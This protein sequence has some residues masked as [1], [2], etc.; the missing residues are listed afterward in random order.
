MTRQADL[1]PPLGWQGGPCKVVERIEDNVRAPSL[2]EDLS[3]KVERGTKLTNPEA[4]KVYTV[5]TE[6]VRGLFKQIKISPHAQYRMDQRGVTVGDLRVFFADF[7]KQFNDWKSQQ[8]WEY[9]R[10]SEAIARGEPIEWVDPRIGHLF[11][12]FATSGRGVADIVTTYWQ[13]EPDPRAETCGTHPEHVRTAR[14]VEDMSGI[15]TLVKSPTPSKSDTDKPEGEDGKYP[16]QGLPSPW[17]RTKP[18]RGP[19]VL[20]VPGESGSDSS[21]T[22]HE[23]KVRTKGTPGGQYN[24]GDTHPTPDITDSQITPHRRP[25]MAAG[26][27]DIFE[28]MDPA[29]VAEAVRLAGMYPPAFPMGQKRHRKQKGQ[30]YRYDHKRYKRQRG[31]IKRRN[32]RRYKV[33][34][35]NGRFQAQRDREDKYPERF[36][37]KPSGG[38][39]TI[40]ERSQKQ[41][42]KAKKKAFRPVPF[43]HYTL[44]QQGWL[45]EVTPEGFVHYDIRGERGE[46]DLN[47]FFDEVVVDDE[48]FDALMAYID[49]VLGASDE[50]DIDDDIDGDT[51]PLF[52]AWLESREKQAYQV[53]QRPARRRQRQRGMDRTQSRMNYRRNR[54]AIRRRSKMRYRRLKNNPAFK[55][56]QKIRR[57]HPE[58]FKM[59][60][61]FQ[62]MAPDIAFVFITDEGFVR[63]YVLRVSGMSKH[64]NYWLDIPG[65]RV[66]QSMPV[67]DFL[68]NAVFLSDDDTDKMF[69]LVDAEIGLDAYD[70]DSEEEA[71]L[72]DDLGD[73]DLEDDL[74]RSVVDHA[75]GR[76]AAGVVA[77]FLY[78]KRPPEMPTDIQYDRANNHDEWKRRDR[79]RLEDISE[80]STNN[81]GEPGSKVL[82]GE[83]AGHIQKQ[84]ALIHDIQAGCSPDLVTKARQ[85][86][87]QMARVDAKNAMWLFNVEGSKEPY[88]VRLQA[89]R[90]GNV[91]ALAKSH[92]RVSCTC[93]F[94]QW[95][96]P[97]HWAKQ[98]EYLYGRPM[99][100]A[101]KPV[102]KDPSGQHRA[103]KHVLATLNFVSSRKW[104]LPELRSKLGS[105]QYLSATLAQSTM[106]WVA[107]PEF[108]QASLRVVARYLASTRRC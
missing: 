12:V 36:K 32:R 50:G 17:S 19:T 105:L 94:W 47:S 60:L 81:D 70:I 52:D 76:W 90:K 26:E 46:T 3:E 8:A 34:K 67:E 5:E 31:T 95:Q 20:N 98:G 7:G 89:I 84:A 13:G 92:V 40:A 41:R 23:D 59:R 96:G 104:D 71:A 56:Q 72:D 108:D 63:G 35:P 29:L 37:T 30:A 68:L 61:G 93:P 51:D 102:V 58:R 75:L 53:Q 100:S 77:D 24:N 64:V 55:R 11:V 14:E 106:G 43:Y 6:S 21:G 25:S 49:Q 86:K 79:K 33:L 38:V 82:P 83:G 44:D 97:E 42:D 78:E 107:S 10:Y 1:T 69:D 2:R 15:R 91:K 99:G 65:R 48:H 4:A 16:T 18:T 9:T 74:D 22:I 87:V 66:P 57:D 101:T 28:G 80:Y 54:A 85:L 45:L 103:C 39:R 62:L 88:R 27:P 73:P